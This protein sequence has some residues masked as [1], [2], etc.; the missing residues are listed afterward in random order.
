MLR[1]I[2]YGRGMEMMEAVITYGRGMDMMEAYIRLPHA[3][4]S[5]MKAKC[6]TIQLLGFSPIISPPLAIAMSFGTVW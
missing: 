1:E 2:A 6:I 3:E 4:S 5:L